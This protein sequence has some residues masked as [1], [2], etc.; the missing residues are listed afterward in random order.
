M[1]NEELVA[2]VTGFEKLGYTD[3][4]KIKSYLVSHG[5]LAIALNATPLQSYKSGI[6]DKNASQCNPKSLNHGVV[7][8]GYGYDTTTKKE[9]WIVRN[10]WGA[11]WGEKGYFRMLRGKGTCGINTY[12]TSA[13]LA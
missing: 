5:P 13:V 10:S 8:V 9:Y 1:V 6:L 7:L 11:S 3:E 2:K 4:Q 12:V